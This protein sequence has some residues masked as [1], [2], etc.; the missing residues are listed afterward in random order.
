MAYSIGL[1]FCQELSRPPGS[2][3]DC[4]AQPPSS[5]GHLLAGASPGAQRPVCTPAAGA[6]SPGRWP[7]S[8]G[9]RNSVPRARPAC[10]AA[11]APGAGASGPRPCPTGSDPLGPSQKSQAKELSDCIIYCHS[12]PFRS[13][14]QA[15]AHRRPYETASLPEAKA[16]K[17]IKE[18]GKGGG[19]PAAGG[20]GGQRRGEIP[21][22][23]RSIQALLSWDPQSSGRGHGTDIA[24][25]HPA[26]PPGWQDPPAIQTE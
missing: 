24:F 9:R 21:A 15:L 7:T 1:S 16:R 11:G 4:M 6:A 19:A 23:E 13:F 8:G 10:P 20:W 5:D 3:H 25:K 22:A 12:V 2:A 26:R 18:A 17:L 14:Q